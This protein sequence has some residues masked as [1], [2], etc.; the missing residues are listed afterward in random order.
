MI[1]RRLD[2]GSAYRVVKV[3]LRPAELERPLRDLGW[4]IEVRATVAPGPF[5]WGAG[6]P[7]GE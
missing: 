4:S 5:F 2:D 6:A 3:P 1:R 7:M